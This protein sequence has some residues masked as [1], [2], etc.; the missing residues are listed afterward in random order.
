MVVLTN[1]YK[2]R[3]NEEERKSLSKAFDTIIKIRTEMQSR[4]CSFIHNRE[5]T[6]TSVDL[7]D[8]ITAQAVIAMLI[9]GEFEISEED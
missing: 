1:T 8:T 6:D 5:Y 9:D 7:N 4:K 3:L 2:I